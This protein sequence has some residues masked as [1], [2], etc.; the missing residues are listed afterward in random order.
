MD[1]SNRGVLLNRLADLME[2]DRNYLAVCEEHLVTF[3]TGRDKLNRFYFAEPG[4]SR[5]RKTVDHVLQR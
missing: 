5:Q 1:A 4:D 2:R 3:S